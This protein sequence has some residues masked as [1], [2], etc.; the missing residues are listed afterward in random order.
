MSENG[1]SR[2]NG[3]FDEDSAQIQEHQKKQ[4]EEAQ[5]EKIWKELENSEEGIEIDPEKFLRDM[6]ILDDLIPLPDFDLSASWQEFKETHH[7]LLEGL[8]S[9]D[10]QS[11]AFASEEER[12]KRKRSMKPVRVA[13]VVVMILAML[14]MASCG[15]IEYII[16]AI[17]N[18]SDDVFRYEV[19]QELNV[20]V[21][22]P[23]NTEVGA[24]VSLEDALEA[25]GV[26]T[27]YVGIQYPEGFTY[28]KVQVWEYS[29]SV[30]LMATYAH[31][32]E[33]IIFTI[34]HY[35]DSTSLELQ[36][37]EKMPPDAECY[38][39][40]G[41]SHYIMDNT[42]MVTATWIVDTEMYLLAGG[43]SSVEMKRMIDSIYEG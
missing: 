29:D 34:W 31:N 21:P 4:D 13:L 14:L 18:W 32:E 8:D 24:Y 43:V 40:K 41:I 19:T 11:S 26:T 2:R 17:A 33:E 23:E 7:N 42:A 38:V 15:I 27:E 37:A 35:K 12:P 16:K 39:S 20:E 5:L 6:A 22:D 3:G 36:T 1:R 10:Q 28:K 9:A 30:K 25:Y